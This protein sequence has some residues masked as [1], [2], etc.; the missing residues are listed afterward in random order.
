MCPD[1][2][3]RCWNELGVVLVLPGAIFASVGYYGPPT[4]LLFV[5]GVTIAVR[6]PRFAP[7]QFSSDA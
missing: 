3:A 5:V 1:M 7:E 4:W 2:F 6:C